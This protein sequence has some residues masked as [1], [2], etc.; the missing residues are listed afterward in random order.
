MCLSSVLL[1]K[2]LI[3][4]IQLSTSNPRSYYKIS[5]QK[6]KVL[7]SLRCRRM[8]SHQINV[9]LFILLMSGGALRK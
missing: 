3:C 6:W 4:Q 7:Q 2:Q 8:M 9:I 5:I 1:L